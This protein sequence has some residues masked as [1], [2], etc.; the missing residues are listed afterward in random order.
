MFQDPNCWSTDDCLHIK[1]GTGSII[2]ADTGS[3]FQLSEVGDVRLPLHTITVDVS[4]SNGGIHRASI[5]ISIEQVSPELT[6]STH[7]HTADYSH[8]STFPYCTLLANQDDGPKSGAH[9]SALPGY[10]RD[11]LHM[12]C[13]SRVS[14]TYD[15]DGDDDEEDYDDDDDDDQDYDED[16]DD[17]DVPS[18]TTAIIVDLSMMMI[19]LSTLSVFSCD[20]RIIVMKLVSKDYRVLIGRQ[21]GRK[22]GDNRDDVLRFRDAVK[23]SFVTG[24]VFGCLSDESHGSTV[25]SEA[26]LPVSYDDF[27]EVRSICCLVAYI[28]VRLVDSDAVDECIMMQLMRVLESRSSSLGKS[29]FA[30]QRLSYLCR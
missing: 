8:A 20:M 11:S 25:G 14:C 2:A 26:R 22:V 16:Y 23:V 7:Y 12:G 27:L 29:P 5:R 28:C 9:A 21:S 18:M 19:Y 15:D 24:R 3:S 30:S 4:S 17:D 6:H 1:T 13:N 10:I